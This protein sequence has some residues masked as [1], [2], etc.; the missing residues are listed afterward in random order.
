MFVLLTGLMILY[1]AAPAGGYALGQALP[2]IGVALAGLMVGLLTVLWWCLLRDGLGDDA[3][4]VIGLMILMW[5]SVCPALF[6]AGLLTGAFRL[7]ALM[8]GVWAGAWAAAILFAWVPAR[9][10]SGMAPLAFVT[11]CVAG[12]LWQRNHRPKPVA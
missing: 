8:L 10:F 7:P 11:C 12:G 4:D 2:R 9:D 3:G 5:L 6:A 1:T